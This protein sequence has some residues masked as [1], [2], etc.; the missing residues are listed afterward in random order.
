MRTPTLSQITIKKTR[1]FIFTARF[2]FTINLRTPRS[3]NTKLPL[4]SAK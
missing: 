1:R 3:F 2:Y 4:K